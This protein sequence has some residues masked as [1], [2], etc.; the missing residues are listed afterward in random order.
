MMD[1]DAFEDCVDCAHLQR[2]VIGDR[3][4]VLPINADVRACLTGDGIAQ[5]MQRAD[6]FACGY[7]P[8]FS[9]GKDFIPYKMQPHDLGIL[10]GIAIILEP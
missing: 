3:F 2:R 8:A 6:K 5:G 4:V 1:G 9:Y 7:I 10:R